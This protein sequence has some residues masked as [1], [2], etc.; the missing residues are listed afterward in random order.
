MAKQW[1]L[2]NIFPF[3]VLWFTY[4]DVPSVPR[5]L[6]SRM[7]VQKQKLQTGRKLNSSCD[8]GTNRSQWI[9]GGISNHIDSSNYLQIHV[10]FKWSAPLTLRLKYVYTLF[11]FFFLNRISFLPL[12]S[13]KVQLHAIRL[14][15]GAEK[16]EGFLQYLSFFFFFSPPQQVLEDWF[17]RSTITCGA[18]GREIIAYFV[19]ARTLIK[20]LQHFNSY[21]DT[22]SEFKPEDGL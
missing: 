10:F 22:V 3:K 21:G 20:G 6:F 5:A 12:P 11:S 2:H 8:A 16:P 13:G 19:T 18:A 14:Q 4:S 15:R 17:L 7:M 9:I 1:I